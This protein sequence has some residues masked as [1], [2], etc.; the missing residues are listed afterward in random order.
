[1]MSSISVHSRS[2]YLFH[3]ISFRGRFSMSGGRFQT[4]LDCLLGCSF[5]SNLVPSRAFPSVSCALSSRLP[6]AFRSRLYVELI[7]TARVDNSFVAC[8]ISAISSSHPSLAPLFSPFLDTGGGAFSCLSF[9]GRCG[10]VVL[11]AYRAVAASRRSPVSV[12]SLIGSVRLARR[13]RG[14]R[15]SCL[16]PPCRHAVGGEGVIS[17]SLALLSR[18]G[19]RGDGSG[20]VGACGVGLRFHVRLMCYHPAPVFVGSVGCLL[21]R[22]V[23]ISS[24][25][26]SSCRI[27]ARFASLRYSPR[28]ATRWAGRWLLSPARCL[29]RCLP[30]RV[31]WCRVRMTWY[32]SAPF[33]LWGRGV[34][35]V[36]I[37]RLLAVLVVYLYC[38]L[39]VY[40]V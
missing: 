5:P 24:S 22:R 7:E 8:P 27:A 30:S 12:L 28:L 32:H 35:V 26:R 25:S 38:Q 37:G 19:G 33:S 15:V 10:S 2:V 18:Y 29:C 20:R 16:P 40:I 36:W 31:A 4:V 3:C 14:Y 1:M 9:C 23:P 17:S 39:V 34:W 21:R 11:A 6:V 13:P